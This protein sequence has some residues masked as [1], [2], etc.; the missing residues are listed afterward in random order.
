M[1]TK[2]LAVLLSFMLVFS[3]GAIIPSPA[4][5]SSEDDNFVPPIITHPDEIDKD[6]NGIEDA[7]ESKIT[8]CS[9]NELEEPIAVIVIL[10]QPYT[11]TD[12]DGFLSA[13]GEI[14]HKYERVTYGFSGT[15]PLSKINELAEALGDKLNIIQQDRPTEACLDVST[16]II[17]ARNTVWNTY[18]YR[19]D[20]DSAIAV[21]DSGIDDSHTDLSGY[22]DAA[23]GWP[24]ANIKVVGW[25]DEIGTT[26]SPVDYDGHGT[27]TA[28]IAS[29]TG[30][31]LGSG[32]I[33]Q[34]TTTYSGTLLA[35]TG[36][37]YLDRILL[38]T[39]GTINLNMAWSGTGTGALDCLDTTDNWMGEVS[40]STPP[41]IKNYNAAVAGIH[42]PWCA[43]YGGLGG[44][45]FSCLETYP[46]THVGDG[47][48]LFTGVSPET[49]LV[50]VRVFPG[51]DSDMIAGYDWVV[52]NK[53]TYHIKVATTSVGTSEAITDLRNAAN[54]VV[55]NG[56]V[57]TVAAGNNYP[58]NT[59]SDPGLASK[60][61][62]VGATND[63]DGIAAYS[64]NGGTGSNKPDVVAPGGS[65]NVGSLITAVDTND[66]DS[67]VSTFADRNANDY[68]NM[69]GTSMST[70]H[71]GGLAALVIQAMEDMGLTWT[72]S[73]TDALKVKSII[74]MTAGETNNAVHPGESTND[75]PLN[76]GANDLVEGYG[77][78]NADAAIEAVIMNYTIG[79]TAQDTLGQN[80]TNKRVWARQVSLTGGQ[81][82]TFSLTI[83]AGAD[84]ALYLYDGA[85]GTDGTPVIL[86]QNTAA[87]TGGTETINYTPTSSTNT[88]I[89]VKWVN[90]SGQ[91]S[92]DST[93][94]EPNTP[95][96]VT[97][98]TASQSSPTVDIIYDVSDAEQS[99]VTIS[100]E[101]WEGSS[102]LACNTTT[103]EGTQ[104]TGTG[105]SGTWD[106][107]ADFDEHYMTDCKIKVT[108]DD[109]Q[110][111][112]NTG[113]GESSTF[114]LDTKDPSGYGCSSPTNGTTNVSVNP[115]LTC[116]SASDDSL[117]VSYYF[118]LA[119]DDAFSVGL[120]E[121]GW[122]S[123]TTWSPSTLDHDK[124][125]F[126]RAKAKDN[127][128]N[129]SGYSFTFDFNTE[130]V[131]NTPPVLS[132][133]LVSPAS[134]YVTT[135]FTYSVTYTDA[136]NDPP[137]SPTLSI[138]GGGPIDMTEVD[139]GDTD[140]TDGKDYQYTTS[141]L[142]KDITHTYQFAAS[143]GVD[144][145]TGDTESHDGPTVQ[146]SPP[147]MPGNPSPANNATGISVNADLSWT[148]GDPDAGDTAT[149]DVYFGTNTTPPLVSTNQTGTTY[150]PGTLAD[151]TIYYW[152]IVARDNHGAE[153]T[154]PV[155]W[156][157]TG[158]V[159]GDANGDGVVDTGD[160]TKIK[161][162]YF[163][164]DDPTPCADAN[165]DGLVDTGD[166]TKVKR[167]Y[168]EL[169]DPTPCADAKGMAR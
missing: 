98:V 88:Y 56:I 116:F 122:Q 9:E 30:A 107:K 54:T 85:P 29:G 79:T 31:R 66:C 58:D 81:E 60:V 21:I 124:Q 87:A 80:P 154:G 131:P 26:T 78:V 125:Y 14:V 115:N 159:L 128:D 42:K 74:L 64:S 63:E 127:Y 77:R 32:T 18:G 19:G 153:S 129:E 23:G 48:N 33:T 36:S 1:K 114:I 149:Y 15:V 121:S 67:E 169:D 144:D 41:I 135:D 70:P 5:S 97:S 16:Q 2:A 108:A 142:A 76:R 137:A 53:N 82:Y 111:E 13:G 50:G 158:E 89:V 6:F 132:D 47:E 7:L 100:F 37:G 133:G 86:E 140:Y 49:R 120:Q 166:I 147:N 90:G 156:F 52:A 138:D 110:A 45:P 118:Q 8:T 73:E 35:E 43:H 134:G 69:S 152:Q 148:G 62:T 151:D 109:G 150:D 130:S 24:A 102:W 59:I 65:S 46:Y 92:L 83:P 94:A 160:I 28:S 11:E 104:S 72:W 136:D 96:Q 99:D 119:E 141:G 38:P 145:A 91:F 40:S 84:F 101:Y 95:P 162:I 126:W 27:H 155:W 4:Q 68:T 112:N 161:R 93:G 163:G 17:G 51:Y 164:I 117:P 34:L 12:I 10:K 44:Q 39:T 55:A 168:F 113:T 165:M 123:S 20:P 146:N 57:F 105:K 167:I 61:I 139:S 22:Q 143:D 106:A 3:L 71:V 75:P 103:S 25:D 157:S